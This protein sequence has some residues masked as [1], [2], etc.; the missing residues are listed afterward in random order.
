MSI[1][2]RDLSMNLL[3]WQRLLNPKSSN[4]L[5]STQTFY[6]L[7]S[8]NFKKTFDKLPCERMWKHMEEIKVPMISPL[9]EEEEGFA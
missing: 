4:E 7:C 2:I 3:N 5:S 1:I 6:E 8:K 9:E